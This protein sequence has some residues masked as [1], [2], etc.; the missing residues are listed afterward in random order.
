MVS[1]ITACYNSEEY[2]EKCIQSIIG[3]DSDNYEHIIIDGVSTD[4]TL[5][6]IKKYE[7]QYNM[8]WI[9]EPDN[10]M[11]DAITKG[12][13]MANGDIIAWLN[14]DDTYMPWAIRTMHYVM[15]QYPNVSWCTGLPSSQDEKGIPTLGK[16]IQP[17]YA[18]RMI[19][20]GWHHG[21]GLGFIQQESTFWRREAL[22]LVDLNSFKQYRAAGDYYLW[23]SFAS[24]LDLFSVDTPIGCFRN[25]DGQISSNLALY[26]SE[27]KNDYSLIKLFIWF[28]N[29]CF[30]LNRIYYFVNR[31]KILHIRKKRAFSQKFK[32]TISIQKGAKK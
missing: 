3:Q 27:I 12:F 16:A 11:Y 26:F 25:H 24:K 28:L 14:S 18:R 31:K 19:Y 29:K 30:G 4:R 20:K 17:A 10:G 1:I 15:E 22:E 5:E 8:R 7:N 6:I 23:K 2:I 9:S 21:R 13:S 32:D